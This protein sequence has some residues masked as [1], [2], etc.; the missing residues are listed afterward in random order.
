[1]PSK[2]RSRSQK[3]A[4]P[5]DRERCV[6]SVL[7]QAT[8]TVTAL[9]DAELSDV[10]LTITNYSL[11]VR[12]DANDK[13]GVSALAE[14]LYMDRTTLTR[15]LNPL[16]QAG[17]IVVMTDT[18]RRRR[19]LRV[20]AEGQAI[21]KRAFKCWRRAQQKFKMRF[22]DARSTALFDILDGTLLAAGA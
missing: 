6:C 10:G 5:S 3:N 18:D 1:M 8:R 16:L 21:L 13:I 9:Y 14:N 15:N 11:L 20:T 7:R 22:G 4:L 17:L 19:L 12:I 2:P